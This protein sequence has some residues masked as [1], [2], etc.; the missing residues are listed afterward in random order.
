MV[1]YVSIGSGKKTADMFLEKVRTDEIAMNDFAKHAYLAIMY[2]NQFLPDIR[3]GVEPNAFPL[4]KYLD[5][6][7]IWDKEASEQGIN[8][9]RMYS[10]EKLREHN[11]QL[12]K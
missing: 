11:N 12:T 3:V 5:Y 6:D 8:E 7:E 2:M 4:V 10:E 1:D 9:F